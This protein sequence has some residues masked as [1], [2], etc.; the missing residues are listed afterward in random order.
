MS[1]EQRFLGVDTIP[2]QNL[3]ELKVTRNISSS[4]SIEGNNVDINTKIFNTCKCEIIQMGYVN[5][6]RTIPICKTNLKEFSKF[7]EGMVILET[8]P[9]PVVVIED[10]ERRY[11][12]T[13]FIRT[14][15]QTYMARYY[16]KERLM[17][18]V[19]INGRYFSISNEPHKSLTKFSTLDGLKP[20]ISGFKRPIVIDNSSTS[21]DYYRSNLGIE[22]V[23]PTVK[24]A[25]KGDGLYLEDIDGT[26]SFICKLANLET[27]GIFSTIREVRS[28]PTNE[29]IIKLVLDN[30][31]V[32]MSK[33]IHELERIKR[34]HELDMSRQ[35]NE[36]A[37]QKL[38][39]E[40]DML[41]RKHDLELKQAED[42]HN[43]KIRQARKENK[44]K[45]TQVVNENALKLSQTIKEHENKLGLII[46]DHETKLELSIKENDLK[47]K[48]SDAKHVQD[49]KQIEDRFDRTMA[50][51]EQQLDAEL[52]RKNKAV[53]NDIINKNIQL[54]YDI[55]AKRK[56]AKQEA[57][58]KERQHKYTMK[59]KYHDAKLRTEQFY[60]EME[61][62]GEVYEMES[63]ARTSKT[64]HAIT[65]TLLNTITS[66]L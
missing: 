64:G 66:W 55:D 26:L 62:K 59:L 24:N 65:N 58:I 4:K 12:N 46:K 22:E 13:R 34:E 16:S 37:I 38:N 41:I 35:K 8:V 42:A 30:G 29:E 28:L 39:A 36:L 21:V 40:L 32:N 23:V 54:E 44:L 10:G 47:L 31:K 48:Q 53:N 9:D 5:S 6:I 1:A 56:Q 27:N 63:D 3:D 19:L 7:D 18:G 25:D 61:Q 52:A 43:A 51:L 60:A 2:K 57:D 45:I 14:G 33:E 49:L 20:D 11:D 50:D 15:S 17:E